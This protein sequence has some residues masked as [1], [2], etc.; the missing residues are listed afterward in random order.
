MSELTNLDYSIL[1]VFAYD[2]I[3]EYLNNQTEDEMF[4]GAEETWGKVRKILDTGTLTKE[5]FD[6]RFEKR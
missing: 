1:L 2:R 4:E 6:A 5:Q 3:E